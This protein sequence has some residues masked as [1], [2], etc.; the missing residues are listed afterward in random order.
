VL[1]RRA[2]GGGAHAD[3]T[4]GPDSGLNV[5]TRVQEYGGGDYV[6]GG[7]A[8][9]FSNFAWV[10]PAVFETNREGGKGGGAGGTSAAAAAGGLL[11][12]LPC[13]TLLPW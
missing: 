11:L 9:Y 12:P 7:S 2:A 1:V 10:Q 13:L 3:V 4:P 8:V 5:R 6:L